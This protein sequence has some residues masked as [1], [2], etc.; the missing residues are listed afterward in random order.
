MSSLPSRNPSA[1]AVVTL[2]RV[3]A[4]TP[5]GHTLFSDLSLAFGRERTG[6]VGRN[7]S[8][9][10]TLL[11]LIVGQSDPAEG[12]VARTG[13]V[14]W[15]E[16]RR[17]PGAG[18]TVA[19]LLGVAGA[20][21]IVARVL[22]GEA[23]GDDLELADWSL[24]DRIA[25]ALT[26]VGLPQLEPERPAM[27]LSGGE[28]TRVRL[29][30]LLLRQPDLLVLDEPTNHLDVDGR[31]AI[32]DLL[33]RWPGGAVV[34]SHDRAL[35][36]LMDRIVELSSLGAATYGG[37]YD[38][39]AGR[40]A[41]ERAAAERDLETAE[42]DAS[43]VAR[44]NQRA[45]ERKARRD[46]AGRAFAARASEPRILLGAMA[47]RAENSGARED[48]LAQRRTER[49]EVQLSEARE[50]VE[51]I[52]AL[53][54]PMP[55][56]R[57]AA[58]RTVAVLDAASWAAPSGRLVLAPTALRIT[59]PERIAITGANGSGKTTLL[60]LVT[61]AITP[62]SGRVDRPVRAA[63]LDQDSAIL[64]PRETLL[65]AWLRL[66]PGGT[67]NEAYAA[68]AR[69]LF[70]N[71]AAQR[72][73][74]ALSGGER[75]RAALACVMTGG[76]PP[77]MLVLDE[78]TNHLDLDSI[79]AVEAA[80]LAYD[81]ALVVVSHDDDFLRAIGTT[82]TVCLSSSSRPPDLSGG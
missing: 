7:G 46:K 23:A 55:S 15:L 11:R 67:P 4:R 34:V 54:I 27:S 66:N 39:Y 71:T 60:K 8:G 36:R 75:L 50:R 77:Q 32:A 28:Q 40:K 81:G 13:D 44:E 31:A 64:R 79:A 45:V 63:F 33:G 70:R 74:G 42:R 17:D 80:L 6:I 82:R 51:R 3:A 5:D 1:S 62:T 2:D 73:V 47:E 37:G 68:L 14:A 58:G 26:D 29:A 19:N 56:T 49:A 69:F 16:Q 38:L 21:A 18:D 59:G 41:A 53:D 78:P 9:K 24:D 76:S 12:A 30:G 43:R 35:L 48:A 72:T 10:T 57:L 61:G 52:R 25:A 20:L 65:D 22:A